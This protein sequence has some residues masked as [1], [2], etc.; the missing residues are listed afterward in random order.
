MPITEQ[1]HAVLQQGK[2]VQDA[3]RD[4]M[5]RPSTSEIGLYRNSQRASTGIRWK[6]LPPGGV[7]PSVSA[8]LPARF[9]SQTIEE[10]SHNLLHVL[11]RHGRAIEHVFQRESVGQRRKGYAHGVG[12]RRQLASQSFHD[13]FQNPDPRAYETAVHFSQT[14]PCLWMADREQLK[15][16]GQQAPAPV[17]TDI[18]KEAPQRL[19]LRFGRP[20]FVHLLLNVLDPERYLALQ[21]R[22][23]QVFL[24]RE[25]RVEGAARVAGLGGDFLQF[26]RLKSVPRKYLLG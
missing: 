4:L 25:V 20:D 15:F 11:F 6:H 21:Q 17:E 24:A 10:I 23:K 8:K 12:R 5:S 9:T 1:M 13:S 16:E 3:I 19:Q 22:K 7:V 2:S 26:R 18:Q 14:G